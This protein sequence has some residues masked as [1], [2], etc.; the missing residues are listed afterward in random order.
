MTEISATP[1]RSVVPV[2]ALI[3]ALAMFGLMTYLYRGGV[4]VFLSNTA[5]LSYVIILGMAVLTCVMQ[6]RQQGQ[7]GFRAALRSAF[8][9][10]FIGLA[11]CTLFN[12]IV[13]NFIDLKFK[14]AVSEESLKME[15]AN[16]RKF[17]VSEDKIEQELSAEKNTDFFA[18]KAQLQGLALYSIIGFIF[19]LII[20]A[21]VKSRKKI[22]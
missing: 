11:T 18:L 4:Y 15:V 3:T 16:W 17:G 20:A 7:L 12:Y 2:Y 9:I 1:K 6:K 22:I 10:I 14:A 13:M 21:L 8:L 5:Y 19:A